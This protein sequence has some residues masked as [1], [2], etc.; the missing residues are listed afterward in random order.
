[1]QRAQQVDETTLLEELSTLAGISSI[2]RY[3]ETEFPELHS[4]ALRCFPDHVDSRS[5]RYGALRSAITAAI[6]QIDDEGFADAAQALVGYPD[7]WRSVRARCTDAG[8]AF[9]PVV[10]YDTFRRAGGRSYRY[11]TLRLLA[12]ALHALDAERGPSAEESPD[13]RVT[14][15]TAALTNAGAESSVRP[16][17]V[18][19][20]EQPPASHEIYG[21]SADLDTITTALTTHRLVTMTGPAGVGKTTLASEI[22]RRSKSDFSEVFFVELAA[23]DDPKRLPVTVAETVF[24]VDPV[25][26]AG[27][28]M[29]RLATTLASGSLLVLDNCEHVTA[30][31]RAFAAEL[32]DKND[33]VVILA[34]SREP[35][36]VDGEVVTKIDPLEAEGEDSPAAQLFIARA[37]R[38]APGLAT[39]DSAMVE[40]VCQRLDG[41]PLAIELTSARLNVLS[42]DDLSERLLEIAR[43]PMRRG[44]RTPRH[45]T[46]D[47]AIEWSY[48]LLDSDEQRVLGLVSIFAGSFD[49][50]AAHAVCGNDAYSFGEVLDIIDSLA[51]RSFIEVL[52]GQQRPRFRLLSVIRAYARDHVDAEEFDGARERHQDHFIRRTAALSNNLDRRADQL[53]VR[54]LELE[55]ESFLDAIALSGNEKRQISACR[56][57][58]NLRSYWEETGRFNEGFDCIRMLLDWPEP[59]SRLHRSILA[60]A[61]SY[62]SITGR[63]QEIVDE[64]N[65]LAA[66]LPEEP[67]PAYADAYIALGFAAIGRAEM[68]DAAQWFEIG[69]E[70]I[71]PLS[72]PVQRRTLVIAG[73]CHAYDENTDRALAVLAEAKAVQHDDDGAFDAYSDVFHKGIWLQ[74][75]PTESNEETLESV[76]AGLRVLAEE[77]LSAHTAVAV[78]Q[79]ALGFERAQAFDDFDHWVPIGLEFARACGNRWATTVAIEL[80]AWSAARRKDDEFAATC[81]GVA[82]ASL[83]SSGFALP[84]AHRS[85]SETLRAVVAERATA[86]VFDAA[87]ALGAETELAVF[88]SQL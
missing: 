78:Q 32:L 34:T 11:N 67:H 50:D 69:A 12:D 20:V 65:M 4:L 33:G 80:L 77:D 26:R 62:G 29:D 22:L 21:R 40:D 73:A 84:R 85:T 81:W 13:L 66:D 8:R 75:H 54:D 87:Y 3:Y 82:D 55:N 16:D 52:R 64:E 71:A 24:G 35:L 70:A 59:G 86:S 83:S 68:A 6:E 7:R 44:R 17:P 43:S 74:A 53:D 56:L 28:S 23:I 48:S 38:A 31:A 79:A 88:V 76:R 51:A 47:D 10:A 15:L 25:R 61:V 14:S 45:A 30:A 18:Y 5:G 60:L 1:M 37:E 41:H 57:A 46:L 36:E 49:L 72:A 58:T 42:L 9:D 27:D 63:S 2:E 39:L 19:R